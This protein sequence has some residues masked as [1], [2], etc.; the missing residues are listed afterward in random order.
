M[1]K[2]PNIKGMKAKEAANTLKSHNLNINIDG[3]EG[4]VITQDPIFDTEVEAGSVIDVVIKKELV[5]A[6]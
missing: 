2:V 1:V 4:V 5:D 3:T 6:H